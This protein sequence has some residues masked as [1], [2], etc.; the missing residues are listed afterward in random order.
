[1]TNVSSN[2]EANLEYFDQVSTAILRWPELPFFSLSTYL[3]LLKM[4]Y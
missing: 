4:T 2:D 3:T 1:M